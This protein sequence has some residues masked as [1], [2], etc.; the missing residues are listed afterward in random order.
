MLK[1]GMVAL[2]LGFQ[3]IDV[4]VNIGLGGAWRWYLSIADWIVGSG[5]WGSL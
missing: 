3:L 2:D 4:G 1:F 5:S